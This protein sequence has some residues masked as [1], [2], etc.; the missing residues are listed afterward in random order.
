[1]GRIYRSTERSA[2]GVGLA[3]VADIT[4]TCSSLGRSPDQE[5]RLHPGNQSAGK[6][7]RHDASTASREDSHYLYRV[8]CTQLADTQSTQIKYQRNKAKSDRGRP[9]IR[10]SHGDRRSLQNGAGTRQS[11]VICR[12]GAI[13]GSLHSSLRAAGMHRMVRPEQGTHR[14][15]DSRGSS[16]SCSEAVEIWLYSSKGW[17]TG[18]LFRADVS[19]KGGQSGGGLWRIRLLYLDIF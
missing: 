4:E 6:N 15:R 16:D 5:C 13:G 10:L 8:L 12:G 7:A 19:K 17:M 14:A 1:M 2:P 9:C 18:N 3:G 11:S